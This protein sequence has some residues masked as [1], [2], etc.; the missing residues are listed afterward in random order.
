M[1]TLKDLEY[2]LEDCQGNET[3]DK[4]VECK[5]LRESAIED[6]KEILKEREHRRKIHKEASRPGWIEIL[7]MIDAQ[8]TEWE[9]KIIDY[10]KEKFNITEDDLK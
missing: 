6:I 4:G 8:Y 2:N 1:K 10:I 3:N 5:L 7:G 9:D